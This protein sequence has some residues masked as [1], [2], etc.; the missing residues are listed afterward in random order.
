M[1]VVAG[2][3]ARALF[4]DLPALFGLLDEVGWRFAEARVASLDVSSLVVAPVTMPTETITPILMM[5]QWFGEDVTGDEIADNKQHAFVRRPAEA[6]HV[7]ALRHTPPD[8]FRFRFPAKHS[9]TPLERALA[10]DCV[11][12]WDRAAEILRKLVAEQPDDPVALFQLGQALCQLGGEEEAVELF[13]RSAALAPD[14]LDPRSSL[15]ITLSGLKRYREAKRVHAELIEMTA[16]DFGE[17]MNFAQV[18]QNLG[19][20]DEAWGAVQQ[21]VQRN[22]T[23]AHVHAYAASLAY[24]RGDLTAAREHGEIGRTRLAQIDRNSPMYELIEK[25]LNEASA[26]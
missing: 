3:H 4:D 21:A 5:S 9:P 14:Q 13:K 24:A 18:C 16:G 15:A 2:K 11:A 8:Y 1:V 17:Y 20:L 25:L 6:R 7:L 19:E 12:R 22:P 10:F 26:S 23:S